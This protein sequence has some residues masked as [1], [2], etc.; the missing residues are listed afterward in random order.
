[1]RNRK[2][3]RGQRPGVRKQRSPVRIPLPQKTIYKNRKIEEDFE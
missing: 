2:K 3:R 1:L